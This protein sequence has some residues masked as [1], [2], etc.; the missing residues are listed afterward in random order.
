MQHNLPRFAIA[1][2]SSLEGSG[3]PVIVLDF[4][5]GI[6][7]GATYRIMGASE[8][9]VVDDNYNPLPQQKYTVC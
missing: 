9:G 5:S 2:N 4:E 7:L 1:V 8:T 6:L 3:F